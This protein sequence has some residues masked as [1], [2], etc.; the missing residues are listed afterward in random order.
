MTNKEDTGKTTP[1]RTN[2]EKGRKRRQKVENC[3]GRATEL[4]DTEHE[5]ADWKRRLGLKIISLCTTSISYAAGDPLPAR[6]DP[7]QH[8]ARYLR[9]DVPDGINPVGFPISDPTQVDLVK[10]VVAAASK[11]VGIDAHVDD[12]AGC[13]IGG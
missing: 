4:L 8:S 9:H 12:S 13:S 6:S 1:Q 10:P 5:K 2:I 7:I 11:G 3:T